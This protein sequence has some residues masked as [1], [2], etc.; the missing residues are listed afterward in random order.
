MWSR[1]TIASTPLLFTASP[2]I[3]RG[4]ESCSAGG[5]ETG[6]DQVS[7]LSAENVGVIGPLS[8]APQRKYNRSR[9]GPLEVS[10]ARAE[11][12]K[13]GGGPQASVT[14]NGIEKACPPSVDRRTQARHRS[15]RSSLP[16][17]SAQRAA[18]TN[19]NIRVPSESTTGISARLTRLFGMTCVGSRKVLPLS[20]DRMTVRAERRPPSS[21]RMGRQQSR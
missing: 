4:S 2:R 12:W 7:P 16:W 5:T 6:A 21:A 10:T 19:E 13:A 11:S 8:R 9:N 3:R 14:N 17:V 20:T 18:S 1:L 15:K